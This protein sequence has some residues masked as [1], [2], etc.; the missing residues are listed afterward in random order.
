[1]AAINTSQQQQFSR[2]NPQRK[3][4]S[5]GTLDKVHPVAEAEKRRLRVVMMSM[6][7]IFEAGITLVLGIFN[8]SADVE[9]DLLVQLAIPHSASAALLLI[10]L[11]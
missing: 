10:G 5:L 1:M 7:P 6:V 8:S 4:R 2:S 9:F 3:E 11:T